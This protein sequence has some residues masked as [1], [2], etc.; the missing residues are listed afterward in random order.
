MKT[1]DEVNAKLTLAAIE[2]KLPYLHRYTTVI[3]PILL[4]HVNIYQFRD[5]LVIASI[6][7]QI[8][9]HFFHPH[10]HIPQI[11]THRFLSD[12]DDG[13]SEVI[14]PFAVQY[15]SILKVHAHTAQDVYQILANLCELEKFF[16]HCEN[17][18]PEPRSTT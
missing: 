7:P 11:H 10:V 4:C 3:T 5:A 6:H 18:S 9:S 16:P 8:P 14:V 13:I 17:A 15:I 2:A 12:E 1:G